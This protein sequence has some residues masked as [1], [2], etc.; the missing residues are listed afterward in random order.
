MHIR[1]T[2]SN[3][4]PTSDSAMLLSFTL[5]L[6]SRFRFFIDREQDVEQQFSVHLLGYKDTPSPSPR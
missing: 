4:A 2:I 3:G 6:F 5:D 1:V